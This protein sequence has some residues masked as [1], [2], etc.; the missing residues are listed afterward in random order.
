MINSKY[1]SWIDKL[2]IHGKIEFDT[3]HYVTGLKHSYVSE[4]ERKETGSLK[5]LVKM[6]GKF[7]LIDVFKFISL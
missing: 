6:S 3:L 2:K 5:G 1:I 7:L 4:K